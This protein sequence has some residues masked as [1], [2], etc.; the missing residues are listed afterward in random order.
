MAPNVQIDFFTSWEKDQRTNRRKAH[1]N[2]PPRSWGITMNSQVICVFNFSK[3]FFQPNISE[4]YLVT[5]AA[6]MPL[7]DDGVMFHW[8]NRISNPINWIGKIKLI[9]IKWFTF[10]FF[11]YNL[12]VSN[13]VQMN[14]IYPGEQCLLMLPTM[15]LR[16]HITNTKINTTKFHITFLRNNIRNFD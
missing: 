14:A 6:S 7:F 8:D 3:L 15:Y 4:R 13:N 5:Q 1:Q 2:W 12:I 16:K 9:I 10:H 11:F